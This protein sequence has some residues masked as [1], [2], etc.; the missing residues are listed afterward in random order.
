V[1]A[2]LYPGAALEVLKALHEEGYLAAQFHGAR[3]SAIGDVSGKKGE[4]REFEKD[5]LTVLVP[6]EKVDSVLVLIYRAARIDR[7]H[8]GFMTVE[9]VGRASSY[10]LPKLAEEGSTQF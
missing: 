3:G 2:Y 8:G 9:R 5:V 4:V 6:E 1:T 7:T 10:G